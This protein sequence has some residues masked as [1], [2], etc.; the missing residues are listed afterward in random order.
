M[1]TPTPTQSSSLP[2][3][4]HGA[5]PTQLHWDIAGLTCAADAVRLERHLR[6]IGGVID[7]VVNPVTERAY[8]TFDAALVS[9]DALRE[10]ID[11]AG[12]RTPGII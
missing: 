10:A 11:D 5:E 6:T 2:E 1:N 9:P 4:S 3:Q 7:V 12:F 8:L